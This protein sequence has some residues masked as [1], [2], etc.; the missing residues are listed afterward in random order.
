M[1]D[2]STHLTAATRTVGRAREREENTAPFPASH[3][4]SQASSR[5]EEKPDLYTFWAVN[6]S[7]GRSVG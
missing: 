1:A 6:Y 5:M 2:D 3:G 4:L 7:T